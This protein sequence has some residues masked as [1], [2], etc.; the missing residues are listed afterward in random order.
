MRFDAREHPPLDDERLPAGEIRARGVAKYLPKFPHA[1]GRQCRGE[2]RVMLIEAAH[3]PGRIG[4]AGIG[5]EH[6]RSDATGTG[7]TGKDMRQPARDGGRQACSGGRSEDGRS[8]GPA[9]QA[10]RET[11]KIPAPRRPGDDGDDGDDGDRSISDMSCGFPRASR[12]D[13]VVRTIV[14]SSDRFMSKPLLQARDQ[15]AIVAVQA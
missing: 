9:E 6:G 3:Q 5:P 4:I 13:G 7:D 15:R 11:Q 2:L 10:Q 14:L 8:H 1:A 12:R